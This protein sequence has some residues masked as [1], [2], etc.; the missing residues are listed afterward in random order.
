MT[1]VV[2][3]NG[4]RKSLTVLVA[5]SGVQQAAASADASPGGN[6]ELGLSVAP[7]DDKLR[8]RFGLKRGAEGLVIVEVQPDSAAAAKN[9]R[10]GDLVTHVN[11]NK[12]A[13]A[14]AMKR[15]VEQARR[16]G[17]AAVLFRILRGERPIFVTVELG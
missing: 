7:V 15:H 10:P 8:R 6:A 1:A 11:G 14:A 16:D 2:W 17:R 9:L 5:E 13:A 3:R 12:V 4:G